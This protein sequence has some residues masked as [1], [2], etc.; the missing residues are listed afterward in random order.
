MA[1]I[2]KVWLSG[3][4]VSQPVL[5]RLSSKTPFTTFT[6]Q[7]N[8]RFVDRGG[9]VQLKPNLIRVESLGKSAE[10]TAERVRQGARFSVD[11]YLRQD[12]V[13]GMEQIRVRSF[14]VYPDDSVETVNYKEGL[15]QAIEVLKKS[16]DLPS[17]LKQLEELSNL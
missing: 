10:T 15:K 8:E 11:G 4:V 5:T 7:V 13:D 1:D 6:I 12:V 3:L 9:S 2:N 17:A 16:R 14:A